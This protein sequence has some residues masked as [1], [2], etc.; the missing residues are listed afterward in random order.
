MGFGDRFKKVFN[1]KKPDTEDKNEK[2]TEKQVDK[3][4]KYANA[5]NFKS[6]DD[7]IRRGEKNIILKSDICLDG[8]EQ[9]RYRNGIKLDVDG[10]VIDGDGHSIDA[11]G[12]TGIFE[13]SCR[14]TIKNLILKNGSCDDGGAIDNSSAAILNISNVSFQNSHA[15]NG[16]AIINRS[17]LNITDCFFKS[18][19]SEMGGAIN[20]Q[21][22]SVLNISKSEFTD[23]SSNNA[24]VL[25]NWGKCIIDGCK[26]NSNSSNGAA[27]V[28][29][30]DKADLEIYDSSFKDNHSDNGNAVILNLSDI[31]MEK[32]TFS[33]NGAEENGV[34][35][36]Q[37]GGNMKAFDCMFEENASKI[38][39]GALTNLGKADFNNCIFKKNTSKESLGGAIISWGEVSLNGCEFS[40]NFAKKSG[41]AISVQE[42]ALEAIMCEFKA[43]SAHN[44][45]GAIISIGKVELKDCSFLENEAAIDGGAIVSDDEGILNVTDCEF[46]ENVAE[47]HYGAIANFT[48]T[49]LKGCRFINNTSKAGGDELNQQSSMLNEKNCEFIT[50]TGLAEMPQ[51]EDVINQAQKRFDTSAARFKEIEDKFPQTRYIAINAKNFKYLDDLIHSG[52][53]EIILESNIILGDDEQS[54]Y[55]EGIKIDVDN[56][57][58]DAN[59]HIICAKGK[60][61]IFN[62]TAKNIEIKN[63]MLAYGFRNRSEGNAI[64]NTGSVSLKEC[65]L[66]DNYAVFGGAIENLGEMMIENCIFTKN[67]GFWSASAL[68]NNGKMEI[69]SC[70]FSDHTKYDETLVNSGNMKISDSIFRNNSS[71]IRNFGDLDMTGSMFAQN[72]E[73]LVFNDRE[74]SISD[75]L[76]LENKDLFK[77]RGVGV[78][79]IKDSQILKNDGASVS[80]EGG[81]IK[82]GGCKIFHNFASDGD[83]ITNS[84]SLRLTEVI[85]KDNNFNRLIFNNGGRKSN[86]GMF[87]TDFIDNAAGD[88]L[89]LNEGGFAH[90]ENA[91]FKNNTF[92][93]LN[94]GIICNHGKLSLAKLDFEDDKPI[95]NYGNVSFDDEELEK[96][97]DNH[98]TIGNVSDDEHKYDFGYLDEFIKGNL[99]KKEIVLEHDVLFE[100]HDAAFFEGGIELDMDGITINGNGKVIDASK[101]SR[102]FLVTGKNITLKNII[103]KN[104]YLATDY[105]NLINRSGACIR[106][107]IASDL[108]I[109]NCK[110]INNESESDGGAISNRGR[111]EVSNSTFSDNL[112]NRLGGVVY[113]LGKID[114]SKSTMEN[115]S[116]FRGGA[117]FN[118][119]D[120]SLKELSL[121]KNRQID[122]RLFLLDDCRG[123]LVNKKGQ[124]YISDSTFTDEEAIDSMYFI[125]ND[126]GAVMIENTSFKSFDMTFKFG[127]ILNNASLK[128]NKSSFEKCHISSYGQ[129]INNQGG[130]IYIENTSFAE[131]EI[132][133]DGKMI[134]NENAVVK[135]SQSSF[136]ANESESV[137]RGVNC[138]L[139]ISDS[140]FNE[141]ILGFSGH[142]IRF[143]KSSMMIQNSSFGKNKCWSI[144]DI[145]DKSASISD[146]SF[147]DNHARLIIHNNFAASISDCSFSKNT[148]EYNV[149]YNRKKLN[150]SG[151]SFNENTSKA[152]GCAILNKDELTLSDS[153]FIKNHADGAGGAIS[154]LSNRIVM[155]N[156]LFENNSSNTGGA[157]DIYNEGEIIY[158]E[159]H[160]S[161]GSK[162]VL[163]KGVILTKSDWQQ[164]KDNN[165][166]S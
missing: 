2:I 132:D 36:N 99:D 25:L 111:I 42:G 8:D 100:D 126:S 23:N 20:N 52:K 107:N 142:V 112:S 17:Q 4:V 104:G 74:I 44:A 129:L 89:I 61:R 76:M 75:C 87:R 57:S 63:A 54:E 45:G 137:L 73:V 121:I 153:R 109:E 95:L 12:K 13:V 30:N 108:K 50:G 55:D 33:G 9:S 113:N 138:D 116:A 133:D 135:V 163:N 144:V 106:A 37:R 114:I 18:N 96:H 98:G 27:C 79:Q 43:N 60:T 83:F 84:D 67:Q 62:I 148:V 82:M 51:K 46:V 103:F 115:N 139:T 162:T 34:V 140:S 53:N 85:F 151:C 130:E 166:D 59:G 40:S 26:F 68:R 152:E 136:V 156:I 123:I 91:G 66:K 94:A 28:I 141:N 159:L 41:G 21:P 65:I 49:N 120:V 154:N 14:A 124:M 127:M 38:N 22:G 5:T 7:L 155:D 81:Q 16:G 70:M 6:L 80:I 149:V 56:I 134:L 160:F 19:T 164:Q 146:S 93:D 102:I 72:V 165:S 32:C 119:G 31:R 24:G 58:I 125:N 145:D 131:N 48:K 47:H 97:I 69:I 147:K 35:L 158:D 150:V 110:F 157:D 77:N 15:Q 105:D 78:T 71:P 11:K 122:R 39:A 90:L 128:I 88:T 86:L 92:S 10:L 1:R 161:N 64:L 3:P 29:I 118:M 143:S 117:V 101:S